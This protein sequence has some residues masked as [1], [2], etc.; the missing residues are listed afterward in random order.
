MIDA[1]KYLNAKGIN[2]Y[3]AGKNDPNTIMFGGIEL[4]PIT[5]NFGGYVNVD[6]GGM[7][8][9]I[10]FRT[11]SR[12]F[13]VVSLRDILNGKVDAEKLRDRI[14][15]IGN[16][17]PS[18]GDFFYTSAVPTLE[19]KGVIYGVDYH[20]HVIS[21][22]LSTAIDGRPM[23]NSWGDMEEYIWIFIWGFLPIAVG[24]ITQSVWKNILSVAVT[25]VCLLSCGY[26]MLC[27]W[28]IWIPVAPNLLIL[29]VNG[30]GLS[31]FAFYQ[32]DKFMRSQFFI[33]E[34]GR[35]GK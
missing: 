22:I 17:N 2:S 28:G 23:F 12:P 20:A 11:N 25:G 15:L 32:H 29:A 13:H 21:Q 1:G 18:A 8:I 7:P 16:R 5:Q 26:V 34:V 33:Y 31:A 9:L 14:V 19:L 27:L 6:D 10:N 3:E 30:V 4:P 35:I 24:R